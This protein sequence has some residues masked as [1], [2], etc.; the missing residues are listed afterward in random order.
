MVT[1]YR[2]K[3]GDLGGDV[4]REMQAHAEALR[5]EGAEVLIA[6]CTEVPLVLDNRDVKLELIDPGDLLARRCVGV[7]LG[8]EPLPHVPVS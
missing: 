2:I 7:C 8:W 3:S 6:G 5:A 4:K 1:L